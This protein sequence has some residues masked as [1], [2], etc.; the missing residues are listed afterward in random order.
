MIFR[1]FYHNSPYPSL[2][3]R[4]G[5]SDEITLS[6]TGYNKQKLNGR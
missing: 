1:I 4:E 5:M 3:L 6:L 2:I